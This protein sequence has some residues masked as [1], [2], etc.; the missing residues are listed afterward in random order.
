MRCLAAVPLLAIAPA[1]MASVLVDEAKVRAVLRDDSTVVVLPVTN[2]AG[3]EVG[4]T[5]TV[6]W[7]DRLDAVLGKAT[8]TVRIAPGT[9]AV[10]VP[11]PIEGPS[12]WTRLRYTLEPVRE[13]TRVFGRI[14]ST[15]SLA[16]IAYHVFSLRAQV[17]GTLQRE[18]R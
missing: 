5:V 13:E 11:L 14:Q 2:T 6:E 8:Q 1:G 15:V 9:T 7:L 18:S 10:T 4:A 17:L 16:H 12:I 3:R